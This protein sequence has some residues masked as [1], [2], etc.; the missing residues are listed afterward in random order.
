MASGGSRK[1]GL[2]ERLIF[3]GRQEIHCDA[4]YLK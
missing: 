4:V 3:F 2:E 1:S